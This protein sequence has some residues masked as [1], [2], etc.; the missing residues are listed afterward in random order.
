MTRTALFT[1]ITLVTSVAHADM[2]TV[3]GEFRSEALGRDIPYE[4]HFPPADVPLPDK[5]PVV[6][7]LHGF[8]GDERV[9]RT[10]ALDRIAA[11]LMR[12]GKLPPMAFA[13]HDGGL[14][15]YTNAWDDGPRREDA[16]LE[17]IDFVESEIV[18]S[19]GPRAIAGVSMGGY[20]AVKIAFK[21]PDM[22]RAVATLSGALKRERDFDS[23]FS[24]K[25]I[26]LRRIFGPSDP[27]MRE[28]NDV[29][30][31]LESGR[32]PSSLPLF[33]ACGTEDRY[34]FEQGAADLARTARWAGLSTE[35]RIRS[36]QHGYH[37]WR[38]ELPAALRFLANALQPASELTAS[39]QENQS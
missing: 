3:A 25:N 24:L 12:A 28:A 26:M 9:W 39:N 16:V 38:Q 20:G 10:R 7:F 27:D 37:Y 1:V 35:A 31:M 14:G 21:N 15:F 22:F 8:G 13:L 2:Q 23:G 29:F 33:V 4:V 11:G 17:F 36:G 6:Y 32:V 19:G 5:L 18:V 34:G 30:L